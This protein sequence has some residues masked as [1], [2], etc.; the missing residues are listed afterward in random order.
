VVLFLK[1]RFTTVAFCFLLTNVYLIIALTQ[2][3]PQQRPTASQRLATQPPFLGGTLGESCNDDAA[4]FSCA[5]HTFTVSHRVRHTRKAKTSGQ[6][7]V[8]NHQS[9]HQLRPARA[10]QPIPIPN[11]LQ[12]S[13]PAITTRN[14]V[15]PTLPFAPCNAHLQHRHI[16]QIQAET[17]LRGCCSHEFSTHVRNRGSV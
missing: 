11:P 6:S 3:R 2:Q 12:P 7:A 10:P 13:T 14:T 15:T 17:A 5:C 9:I 1:S 4:V 8:T 16:S